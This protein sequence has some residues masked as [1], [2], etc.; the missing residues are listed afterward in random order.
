MRLAM[1]P[2]FRNFILSHPASS[3]PDLRPIYFLLMQSAFDLLIFLPFTV[4]WVRL[5]ALGPQEASRRTIFSVGRLEW[6][7]LWLQLIVLLPCLFVVGISAGIA[8]VFVRMAPDGDAL[9]YFVALI[10][11]ALSIGTTFVV[12]IRIA[13]AL[14]ATAVENPMK[15]MS[16][17]KMTAGMTVRLVATVFFL[18]VVNASIAFLFDFLGSAV[19]RHMATDLSHA[20]IKIGDSVAHLVVL[21]TLTSFFGFLY[22]DL[23]L[24]RGNTGNQM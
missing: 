3:V 2:L 7:F 4:T 17:W 9:L 13:L 21:L 20:V 14:V 19:S 24:S 8:G 15:M 6:R 16:A 22:R 12:A 5:A 18:G 23:I 1:A 10:W 11:A